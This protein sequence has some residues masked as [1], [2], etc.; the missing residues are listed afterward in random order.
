VIGHGLQMVVLHRG[1]LHA[2]SLPDRRVLWSR[3]PT[4]NATSMH[5]RQIYE[6]FIPMLQPAG[7][8]ASRAGI[9]AQ[10]PTGM[11]AVVNSRYVACHGRGEFSMLDPLTGEV[12]WR[13][14]GIAPRTLLR[15]DN[16][17]VYVIPP[18]QSATY[19]LNAADGRPLNIANL[20]TLI[21]NGIA[22]TPSG[23]VCIE[24]RAGPARSG[25][26]SAKLTISTL[27]PIRGTTAWSHEFAARSRLTFFEDQQLF[28]LDEISAECSLLE[29]KTGRKLLLGKAPTDALGRSGEMSAVADA[30]QIYL[31]LNDAGN[32]FS[33]YI[34]VPALRV[35][36]TLVA[37]HRDGS[38]IAWK[39]TIENQ[40]LL[41]PQ[42]RQ[43]PLLL[44][45]AYDP[46]HLADID[47]NY[48]NVRLL[49]LD[50]GAG[51]VVV[52]D[53]HATPNGNYYRID[54]DRADRAIDIHSHNER[55]R[56]Q[57]VEPEG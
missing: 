49:A 1:L 36:G 19:A 25:P 55:L 6:H 53:V 18:D 45:M 3:P 15:G 21:E 47:I 23:F 26:S 31:I 17:A 38:G 5:Q 2:M 30:Q 22:V 14:R 16:H 44:F 9:T 39:Q 48:T 57:A 33:N 8:F 12:L 28:V 35:S 54:L 41:L 50:K 24:R 4:D 7:G 43:S 40:N 32:H 46:V 10:S 11:L 51:H 37:F 13:R 52:D 27:D 20:L 34:H 29:L 42:L 56:I